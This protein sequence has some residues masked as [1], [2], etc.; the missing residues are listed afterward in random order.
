MIEELTNT[1]SETASTVRQIAK[2]EID[3]AKLGMAEGLSTV[4]IKAI[5]LI[6]KI[7]L[8]FTAVFFISMGVALLLGE[9]LGSLSSGFFIVGGFFL[10]LTIIFALLRKQFIEKPI[11]RMYVDLFF[12]DQ[13]K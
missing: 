13:E 11:V 9:M 8:I 3:R 5:S 12:K 10:I 7:I 4:S 1:T 2:L 6:I